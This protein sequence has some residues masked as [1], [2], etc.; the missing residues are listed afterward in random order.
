M[1]ALIVE[2]CRNYTALS[3]ENYMNR[4][5]DN[6][7]FFYK[8]LFDLKKQQKL[9][10]GGEDGEILEYTKSKWLVTLPKSQVV[11]PR[12]K[13]A[14]K[15]KPLTKWERFR[16]EKGMPAKE[17][18]S[19]MVYDPITKDWV[20]RYGAGSVKKIGEKY[21]WLMEETSKHREAGVDPFTY[22]K[23]EKKMAQEKQN[24][25]EL[26]NKISAADQ[27]APKG[28]KGVNDKIIQQKPEEAT[29]VAGQTP[30]LK[31]REDVDREK[32]RKRERKAL[33]KSL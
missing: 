32:I 12:Q 21:N 26:K 25:R 24:L 29:V 13:P 20:P 14:P 30:N 11:L 31:Q 4:V 17:K 9:N 23:N 16:I 8:Q 3:E 33:L 15:E 19:R 27:M 2:D 6:M 5:Q 18:R 22:A 10:D 7:C 28:N 1:G